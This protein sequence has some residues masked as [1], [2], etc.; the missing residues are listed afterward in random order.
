MKCAVKYVNN[1]NG[2]ISK[3]DRDKRRITTS[4]DINDAACFK[5]EYEALAELPPC[6]DYIFVNWKTVERKQK[7]PYIISVNG[8][9]RFILKKVR[10]WIKTTGSASMA[11]RFSTKPE[12]EKYMAT[13]HPTDK[14]VKFYIAE[15]SFYENHDK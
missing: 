7:A 15:R 1:K 2:Y 4:Y 12:A 10:G 8:L 9:E 11:M 5:S 13:L 6:F 14:S 3:W